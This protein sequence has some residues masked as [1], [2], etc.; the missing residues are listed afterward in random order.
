[1]RSRCGEHNIFFS[2]IVLIFSPSQRINLFWFAYC[3][4]MEQVILLFSLARSSSQVFRYHAAK[5]SPN[6]K[7][8]STDN[9]FLLLAFRF[10]F[11]YS[12][13][14]IDFLALILFIDEF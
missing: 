6:L 14:F 2:Q 1:M 11:T 13:H 9:T 12:S 8:H 10:H 5:S 7:T 4:S 3:K